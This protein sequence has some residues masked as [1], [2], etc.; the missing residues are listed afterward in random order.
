MIKIIYQSELLTQSQL[1]FIVR[2]R[3][4][5]KVYKQGLI[6]FYVRDLSK[7]CIANI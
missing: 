7:T 2:T 1:F 4:V 6:N 5:S 3:K